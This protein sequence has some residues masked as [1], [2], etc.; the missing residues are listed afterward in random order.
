[1]SETEFD[2]RVH[3]LEA[4]DISVGDEIG[5]VPTGVSG[6]GF[7]GHL[8]KM[9]FDNDGAPL[10]F[11][12]EGHRPGQM[13]NVFARNISMVYRIHPTETVEIPAEL[14]AALDEI[15]KQFP[16]PDVDDAEALGL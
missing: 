8:R 3:V 15:D 2:P 9:I 1:M 11:V 4:M 13:L 5:L 12:I 10:I 7:Q 14:Q 6:A 16:V